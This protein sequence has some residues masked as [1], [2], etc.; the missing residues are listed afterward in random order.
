[1]APISEKESRKIAWEFKQRFKIRITYEFEGTH[2]VNASKK[3]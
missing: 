2:S 3:F 1:L